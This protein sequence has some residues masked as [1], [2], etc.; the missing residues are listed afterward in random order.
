MYIIIG[1]G[2]AGTNAAIALRR[3][4]PLTP[5]TVVTSE[6][7]YF[8]SRIDLP[9]IIA[10]KYEAASAVLQKAEDFASLGIDCRMGETVEAI[11]PAEKSVKL[12][13]GE[14]LKYDR[15]LL[16]S[17]SRP[18]IPA[19][20]GID[21][22]GV[23]SL[24]TIEQ[25]KEIAAA[26][27]AAQTAV[28][29]GAGLIGLKTALALAAGGLRVTIVEK[30]PKIM[31]R[32]LDSAASDIL[33][34]RIRES[35][36]EIMTGTAVESI[37]VSGGAVTG[38]RLAGSTLPADMVIMAVGVR[39]NTELAVAAGIAVRHGIIVNEFQ[40][41]SDPDIYAAG[42]C[43]EAS[44]NLT[45]NQTI[46]ATWPVAVEQGRIAA[47]NMAGSKTLFGGS[48]AMNSVEIAGIPLVSVGD[49]DGQPED[50]IFVF[51]RSSTYRK[52]VTRGKIVRGVVCLGDI[53]QAGVIG[54]LVLRQAEVDSIEK[55]ISPFF[56]FAD[57]IAG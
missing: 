23:Y 14:L 31:P 26:A 40:Q 25:A 56:S 37:V 20:P 18:V 5:V 22:R 1:Q 43:A 17:G 50:N 53:R 27:A 49:I 32:Q 15:L 13:S 3:M 6:Q 41:T 28:V 2:A 24:W 38:V 10:G 46:P 36:V 47:Q 30:M 29:V 45:G 11:L 42:D 7:D 48:V 55:L 35:G 4:D 9:D 54:S 51:Q 39:P 12:K 52:V 33:S 8:Y 34:D 19:I 57:L 21:A 16:A 44:D